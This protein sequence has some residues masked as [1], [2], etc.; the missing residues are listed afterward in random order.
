M[1]ACTVFRERG[2]T[3]LL[4]GKPCPA[5]RKAQPCKGMGL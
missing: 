3:F 2:F 5:Q 1:L 4:D